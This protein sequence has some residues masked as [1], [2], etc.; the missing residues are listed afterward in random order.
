MTR[1]WEPQQQRFTLV[2]LAVLA[3]LLGV[4]VVALTAQQSADRAADSRIRL[5]QDVGQIRYYDELLTMSARLAAS[6]GD[7][8]Y[9][10]RYQQAVP[11]LDRVIPPSRDNPEKS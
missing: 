3:A 2:L 10:E 1:T 9:V 6:S 5:A 7:T 8:L 4:Q 11:E